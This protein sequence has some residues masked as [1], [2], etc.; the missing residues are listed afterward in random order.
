MQTIAKTPL[1]L[2]D[3]KQ[4]VRWDGVATGFELFGKCILRHKRN[5]E[6]NN[7]IYTDLFGDQILLLI[8]NKYFRDQTRLLVDI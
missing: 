5:V 1:F 6:K 3:C 8:D 7:E 2:G 4:F